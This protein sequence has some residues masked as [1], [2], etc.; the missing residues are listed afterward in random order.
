MFKTVTAAPPGELLPETRQ[1]VIF[2]SVRFL[3]E[4]L[5]AMPGALAE[6]PAG[7]RDQLKAALIV[8]TLALD[9][10]D[11]HKDALTVEQFNELVNGPL[12]HPLGVFRVT[13]LAHALLAV[14]TATGAAGAR[15]FR[16]HCAAREEADRR[17]DEMERADVPTTPAAG[18][19]LQ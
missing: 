2:T 16:A 5:Q 17:V 14:L 13:R 1:A 18:A 8:A 15:A 3:V 4:E 7:L 6:M 12:G 10:A 9:V 11:D 19:T